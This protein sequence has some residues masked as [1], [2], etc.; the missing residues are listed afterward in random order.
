[1]RNVNECACK[2]LF[3]VRARLLQACARRK[4]HVFTDTQTDI[5]TYRQT[6]RQRAREPERQMQGHVTGRC[7]MTLMTTLCN[8]VSAVAPRK[9]LCASAAGAA[10]V[11]SLRLRAAQRERLRRRSP[12]R[13]GVRRVLSALPRPKRRKELKTPLIENSHEHC[14]SPVTLMSVARRKCDSVDESSMQ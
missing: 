3:N 2:A 6:D 5:H 14:S 12:Q 1:M 11:G 7:A 9:L 13:V 4:T 10:G 8:E